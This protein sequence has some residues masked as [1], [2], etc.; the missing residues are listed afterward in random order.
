MVFLRSKVAKVKSEFKNDYVSVNLDTEFKALKPIINASTVVAYNGKWN[1]NL[2]IYNNCLFLIFTI[3]HE[4]LV[5]LYL[6]LFYV[7]IV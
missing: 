5:F 3:K 6:L 2:F 7:Y 1:S 4:N